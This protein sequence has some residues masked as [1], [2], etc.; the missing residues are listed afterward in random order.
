MR[1]HLSKKERRAREVMRE[2]MLSENLNKTRVAV[3]LLEIDDESEHDILAML[4]IRE[5]KRD[6]YA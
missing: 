2:K 6:S 1:I 4:N 5:D 3:D